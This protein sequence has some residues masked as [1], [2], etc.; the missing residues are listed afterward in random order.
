MRSAVYNK[1]GPPEV[2][3]I[4][5]SKRPTLSSDD[6]VL[7]EVYASTVNR[8]DCSFRS[9]EYFINRVF[10]G[11]NGP[12]KKIL[13]CEYSGLVIE[14]G[15]N[16]KRFKIGDAVFGFSG[17]NFGAH[18]EFISI[19]EKQPIDKVPEGLN[20]ETAAAL[21]EG[22]HYAWNIVRAAQISSGQKV[23][24]NGAT[25]AIG[26]AAVQLSKY[27]GAHVTAVCETKHMD[28]VKSIGSDQVIDY[29]VNDFTQMNDQFDVVLDAVGKSSFKKCSP[30]LKPKGIYVSTE[31]GNYFQNPLLALITPF[32]FGKRVLFPIPSITLSD[33][34]LIKTLVQNRKFRPVIDRIY[35]LDQIVEAYQYVETGMKTGNVVIK[36]K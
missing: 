36:I 27:K 31:L 24:V 5:E 4:V 25:G 22:F 9:A 23:L 15:N 18:A 19:K 11:L 30:L 8:T 20:Y 3:S 35:S 12:K 32:N 29:T 26:S 10:A 17:M 28:L 33:M 1:Y 34:Q 13:G 21:T 14:I 6:E 7:I 16:V 2:V